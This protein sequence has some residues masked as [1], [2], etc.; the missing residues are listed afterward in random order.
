M[1]KAYFKI[2][3]VAIP[4]PLCRCSGDECPTDIDWKPDGL[5]NCYFGL[6]SIQG[7]KQITVVILSATCVIIPYF[8]SLPTGGQTLQSKRTAHKECEALHT[9]AR[10]VKLMS[11]EAVEAFY[12]VLHGKFHNRSSIFT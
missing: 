6:V 12:A 3:I 7:I 11:P 10:L 9:D 4:G 8:Q 1:K 5:G 2:M